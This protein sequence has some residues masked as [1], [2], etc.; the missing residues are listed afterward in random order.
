MRRQVI[1]YNQV[2][3][4]HRY[5]NA[6]KRCGFLRYK[7]RHVF[8]IRC[9]FEVSSNDREIEIITK[10]WEIDNFI[11]CIYGKPANFGCMSCEDIAQSLLLR[12]PEMT[13]CQVLE[14]G[15]GGASL[16]I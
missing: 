12:F 1:T 5:P 9:K 6:P 7:H 3:G 2:E 11:N 4:F 16:A 10:Q 15:Y 8:E 14:D 13:E